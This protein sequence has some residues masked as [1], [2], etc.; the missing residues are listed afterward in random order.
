MD[1]LSKLTDLLKL[2]PRYVAA[3]AIISALLVFMPSDFAERLDFLEIYRACRPYA[4]FV[5]IASIS[6]LLVHSI[7]ELVP[8]IKQRLQYNK[9]AKQRIEQL[10]SLTPKERDCLGD[11]LLF[12]ERAMKVCLAH[13]PCILELERRGLLCRTSDLEAQV[14]TIYS[15]ESW[16]WQHLKEHPEL[17]NLEQKEEKYVRRK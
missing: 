17:V 8:R 12:N 11:Y 15:I 1:W 5:L 10:S 2:A 14:G 4:V 6:I 3:V 9:E 13:N 7:A 16:V